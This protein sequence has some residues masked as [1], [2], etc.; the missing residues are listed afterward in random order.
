MKKYRKITGGC[1][2]EKRGEITQ[3]K[4]LRINKIVYGSRKIGLTTLE[5]KMLIT[6][7]GK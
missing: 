3:S 1:L 2:N 7:P 4:I 6:N 5:K